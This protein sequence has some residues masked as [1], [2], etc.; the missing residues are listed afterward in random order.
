M[1]GL[2]VAGTRRVSSRFED[3]LDHLDEEFD[4]FE[5][6]SFDSTTASLRRALGEA[7]R[8]AVKLR[9]YLSPQRDVI[10]RLAQDPQIPIDSRARLRIRES[11]DR[12][13]RFV[14]DLE[15]NRDRAAVTQEELAAKLA[16]SMN[17]TSYRLTLIA[18]IFLPL[19]FITGLL[20][21]NVGGMPLA[22]NAS[23]FWWVAGGLAVL[24]FA[25][26]AYFKGRKWW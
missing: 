22:E 14:E 18:A 16:E 9:R 3:P 6:A 13:S 2:A 12:I 11:A 1:P 23:G 8:T 17:L 4:A 10:L 5:L 21:I 24:T 25:Q 7:R 20:G 26:I 19:G 15:A